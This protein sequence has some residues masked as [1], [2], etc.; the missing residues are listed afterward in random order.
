MCAFNGTH[1]SNGRKKTNAL[2][3]MRGRKAELDVLDIFNCLRK[4]KRSPAAWISPL[5]KQSKMLDSQENS[6][7]DGSGKPISAAQLKVLE[8]QSRLKI[9][10]T[11]CNFLIRAL[12]FSIVSCVA[13]IFLNGFQPCG[14]HVDESFLKWFGGATVAQLAVLLGVFVTE[15]WR[16]IE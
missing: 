5:R 10:S 3:L 12:G 2:Y 9:R 6:A 14:F 1:F 16:K 7:R 8:L 4:F 15:S 13:L 11:I